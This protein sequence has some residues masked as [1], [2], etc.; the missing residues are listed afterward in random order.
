M[1][2]LVLHLKKEYFEKIKSGKK[3]MEFRLRT[4]YW[5]RRLVNREYDIIRLQCGYPKHGDKENEI[6]CR[7]KGYRPMVIIHPHFGKKPVRVF[8]IPVDARITN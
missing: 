4:P 1:A 8:G 6:L 7:F 5:Q 2:E 3:K